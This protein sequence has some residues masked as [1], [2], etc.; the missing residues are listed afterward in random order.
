M[1]FLQFS[2]FPWKF[3]LPQVKRYL[4]SNIASSVCGYFTGCGMTFD[5]GSSEIRKWKKKYQK[6]ISKFY[7]LV[8]FCLIF[9]AFVKY[10]VTGSR[11][12]DPPRLT[13]SSHLRDLLYEK[14]WFSLGLPSRSQNEDLKIFLVLQDEKIYPVQKQT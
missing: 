13:A 1:I 3:N 8:Q 4:I 12:T 5:L 7:G 2:V 6:Q 11:L 14:N 9:L 10:S